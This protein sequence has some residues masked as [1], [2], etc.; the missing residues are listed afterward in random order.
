[1][2]DVGDVLTMLQLD[3]RRAMVRF[4]VDP[5]RRPSGADNAVYRALE[6]EP[7]TLDGVALLT[8]SGLSEAAMSLARLAA[9]GWV[10]EA[11]GWFECVGSPL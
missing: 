2:L 6:A 10:A 11:D 9:A 8:G 3:H 5:R 7:R 4:P 1:V